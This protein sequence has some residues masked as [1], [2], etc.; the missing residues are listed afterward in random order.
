MGRWGP[1]KHLKVSGLIACTQE[2]LERDVLPPRGARK[3]NSH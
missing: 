3:K 2:V 1:G